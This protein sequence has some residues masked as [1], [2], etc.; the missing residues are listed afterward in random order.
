MQGDAEPMS[1]SANAGVR[2]LTVAAVAR[3][4]GVAPATLRTWARRYDLGP[5][6]HTA[7]SHRRYT[8][9]DFSRLVVMRRLT[10]EGVPPSEAARIAAETPAD[11]LAGIGLAEVSV[12]NPADSRSGR[13]LSGVDEALLPRDLARVLPL[14][15]SRRVARGLA[16]AALS[17]DARGVAELLRRQLAAAG[18]IATW[19]EVVIPVLEGI[20]ARWAATGEGVEIEHQFAET[21]IA[22]LGSITGR[23]ETPRNTA[24]VLLSCAAEEQHSLPLY[25]LAAALAERGIDARVLGARM[26]TDALAAAVRRTGPAVVLV[27]ASMPVEPGTL[28]QV[29][30]RT[31]PTPQLLLGGPGWDEGS[32]PGF[33]ERVDSLSRAVAWVAEAVTA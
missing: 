6:R 15:D 4:L 3:R 33:A 31:R 7:G 17:M 20:G 12:L 8:L 24:Q 2:T 30:R 29:L 32:L 9:E 22:A 23:L 11:Q 25:A 26:P 18:V 27:Y 1:G 10:H 19:E 13:G 14:Q 21:T 5:S 16:R 28:E